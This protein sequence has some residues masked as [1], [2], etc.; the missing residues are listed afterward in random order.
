M[1]LPVFIELHLN[2][3]NYYWSDLKARMEVNIIG[4]INARIGIVFHTIKSE[5]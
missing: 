2:K 5:L 3:L 1:G 4:D